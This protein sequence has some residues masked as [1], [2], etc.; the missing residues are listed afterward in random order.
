MLTLQLASI[1]S[2]TRHSS[3]LKEAF[4]S[5]HSAAFDFFRLKHQVQQK[6][7]Q[8]HRILAKKVELE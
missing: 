2:R 4:G 6:S 8:I 1:Y 5:T 3:D 7:P